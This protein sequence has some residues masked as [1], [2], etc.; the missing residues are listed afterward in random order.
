MVKSKWLVVSNHGISFSISYM[1]VILPTDELIFFKMGTLHQR[2]AK[3]CEILVVFFRGLVD[4]R[5]L[6]V[7]DDHRGQSSGDQHR[8]L[9]AVEALGCAGCV[10]LQCE[11]PGHD[12]VQLVPITPISLWFMV[13]ITN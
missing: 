9:G 12:S 4:G 3:F 1:D 13:L 5:H 6:G 2:P 8:P 11:A 7:V 10:L